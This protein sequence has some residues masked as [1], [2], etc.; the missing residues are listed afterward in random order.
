MKIIEIRVGKISV[1]LKYPFITALR[2]VTGLEDVVVEIY[3]DTGNVGFGEAAPAG[4]ITGDTTGGIV[5]AI[6]DHIAPAIKGKDVEDLEALMK[7][8]NGAL[9]HNT[10]A[11]AAVDMALWDLFGQLH[12]APLYRLLGGS[13]KP[14]ITD[15][16]VSLGAPE[17]M[18]EDS[19]KLV[20]EG[21]DT[22]KI[23]VGND[24][25]LDLQ[26]VTRI[27]ETVGPAIKLRV[28]ANQGW[29]PREAVAIIGDFERAAL[30]IE[31]I[32]QPV[33]A[34]DLEGLKFVHDRTSIPLLAD[35]SVFTPLDAQKLIQM[36]AA[37]YINIKLMKTGGI[38]NALKIVTIAELY[39]VECMIGC[40]LEAK[41]S[42]TAAAHLA[43]AR[44]T[45]TRADLDG[46]NICREDLVI[47][48]AQFQGKEIR[49]G[50][51]PGLGITSIEGIQYIV[52]I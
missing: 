28:D 12:G 29:K 42:V 19:L 18:V 49:L 39:G 47:G 5:G 34:A 24:P 10:G 25:A 2:T 50:D 33:A 44:A 13:A 38:Y 35:E 17:V 48:G 22:L 15:Q 16:T 7:L 31:L 8:L 30:D 26:R 23:K 45:I 21:F 37:D 52:S 46:P 9:V 40:M 6:Q 3:T 11:K 1:P 4:V 20:Q 41:V 51:A 14:I 27:R 32:E 43:A 36:Q